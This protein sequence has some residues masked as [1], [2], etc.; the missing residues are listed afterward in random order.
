MGAQDVS[1]ELRGRVRGRVICPEDAGYDDARRVWNGMIDRRPLAIVRAA[2][3]EDVAPVILTARAAG[4]AI[5]IRGGGHNVAGNGTVDGGIVL[6]LGELDQVEVDVAAGT[7]RAGPGVTLGTLDRA[8]QAHGLAV[9]VGVIS[10]TGVAGL[11]L[12]G[13][14]GWLTRPYGLTVDNLL[15]AEV[16]TASGELVHASTRENEDLLWGL[17]GGGGNFGVVTSF[18]FRAFPLGPSIFGG[19]FFYRRPRW[20]AALRAWAAWTAELPDAMTPIATILVPPAD[21]ELGEEPLLLLQFAWADADH[22][23]GERVIAPLR[24][25]ATPDVE[26]VEP[27]TWLAWQSAADALFPKGVRAYWKNAGLG[28]LADDAIDALVG[29]AETL[30]WP[31]T[32]IDLHHMGGAFARVPEMATPFPDRSA[33]YWLNIYGF[34]RDP[35]D[36]PAHIAWIRALAAAMEP[37]S[38]GGRY[39]NFLASETAGDRTAQALAVYGPQKLARLVELKRRYDPDNVFRLNHN[40]PPG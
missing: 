31:G 18:T 37:F 4:L 2:T 29:I 1:A 17:S 21:W 28:G 32:G 27:T 35:A 5:A 16:V 19:T 30:D 7:V 26:L 15:A 12:G 25:A 20:A 3:T 6:D 8:T 38:T 36:D 10:G 40:I 39:V 33:A 14:V 11:T 9:P 22:A 34:W 24:A 13:G 23:Q